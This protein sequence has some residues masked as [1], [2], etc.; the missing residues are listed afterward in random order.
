VNPNGTATVPLTPDLTNGILLPTTLRDVLAPMATPLFPLGTDIITKF[1][2]INAGEMP[3]PEEISL[4]SLNNGPG[5][6]LNE[7][8][9]GLEKM[10]K[11]RGDPRVKTVLDLSIDFDDL[12]GNG[13]KTEHITF[14]RI[15][16]DATGAVV[17]R[18]RPGVTPTTG[19]PAKANGPSLDTQGQAAHVFRQMTTREIIMRILAEYNLDALVYPYETIPAKLLTGTAGSIAWLSYDGRPNRGYNS[20]VDAAGLPDIGVPAAFNHTVYDRTTRGPTTDETLALN[21]PAV[22]R[23]V[24]LPF[25]V[26]FMGRPWS[27]PVLLEIAAAFEK[28]RGPRKAPPGH[29]PIDGEP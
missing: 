27:E 10:L 11:R 6:T 25:S 13:N 2:E 22:K 19:V 9:Y 29:G 18:N 28:A 4:R 8:R 21:P 26:Q 16:D 24:M 15:N 17:L 3:F 1:V 14:S 23:D 5:G 7:G 12:N 20:F